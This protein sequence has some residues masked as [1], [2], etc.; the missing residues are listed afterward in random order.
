MESDLIKLQIEH[1]S[2]TI[3]LID[4]NVKYNLNAM[5][6]IFAIAITILAGAGVVLARSWFNNIVEKKFKQFEMTVSKNV[7]EIIRQQYSSY[8]IELTRLG[9][10]SV[11]YDKNRFEETP[12]VF[13]RTH[14]FGRQP[15]ITVENGQVTVKNNE[16][17]KLRVDVLIVKNAYDFEKIKL[18]NQRY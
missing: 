13:V 17:D 10:M 12:A 11:P 2:E 18:N 3:H 16:N 5:W 6:V 1:L 14:E 4:E 7:Q 8:T 15:E 9:S